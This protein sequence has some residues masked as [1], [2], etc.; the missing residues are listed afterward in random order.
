[1]DYF[2]DCIKLYDIFMFNLVELVR[3]FY[4]LGLLAGLTRLDP[5]CNSRST[6]T[7]CL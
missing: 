7:V 4:C 2:F 6:H 3:P 5:V 1:M